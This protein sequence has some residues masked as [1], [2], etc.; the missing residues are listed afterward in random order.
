MP[1]LENSEN[2]SAQTARKE[3]PGPE[4]RS[5]PALY[6]FTEKGQTTSWK[7][8]STFFLFFFGGGG[9]DLTVIFWF[10]G[11]SFNHVFVVG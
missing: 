10:F 1:I 5:P 7:M 3:S 11:V 6:K 8:T 2:G 9:W 4:A